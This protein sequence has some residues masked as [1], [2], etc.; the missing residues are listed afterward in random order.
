MGIDSEPSVSRRLLIA[1]AVPLILFFALTVVALDTVFRNLAVASLRQ[2]LEEQVVALVTAVDLDPRGNLVVNLL[3]PDSRLDLPNS[4]QY[5]T[6]RDANGRF[7]WR[8]PSLTG[9]GLSLGGRL[10]LGG[11]IRKCAR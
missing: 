11:T 3:D 9:T 10:P 5:A 1:V 8:S 7:L 4:G 2:V 6:L